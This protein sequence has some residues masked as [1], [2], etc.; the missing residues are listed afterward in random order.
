[1]TICANHFLQPGPGAAP[2]AV[3]RIDPTHHDK[4]H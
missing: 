1:V 2:P 3:P 4:E